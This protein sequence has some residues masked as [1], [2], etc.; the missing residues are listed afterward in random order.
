MLPSNQG[1]SFHLTFLL[2]I[3]G[4]LLARQKDSDAQIPLPAAKPVPRLQLIPMPLSQISFQLDGKELTRYY[5]DASLHRPFLFP[6]NGPSG[7]SLTRMGHPH[8]ANGHSHHNSVWLSHNDV[9]GDI[10]WG[11]KGKGKIRHQSVVRMVDGDSSAHLVTINSWVGKE[12]K[13]LLRER[14]GM[15][16]ELLPNDHWLLT[17]DVQFEPQGQEV[18]FGDTAFGVI[19]VR[20]AK[21]IGIADGG[22][23][24]RNSEGN[25]NE[26]GD[27]GAFRKRARWVDYSGPITRNADEGITLFDHPSNHNYPSPFHVRRDGWMGACFTF[28]KPITLSPQETLRLRYGLLVHSGVP[29]PASIEK[30]WNQ[31]TK[32]ESLDLVKKK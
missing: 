22:G 12:G 28:E 20:M 2:L 16:I 32:S 8:D 17:I 13:V 4:L 6:I 9:N 21:T 24:L 11:D 15:T 19:G 26:Q 3:A 27:N 25:V 18:E 23:L 1:S 14:R 5:Y 30:W 10:F 29:E 7:R 31:F